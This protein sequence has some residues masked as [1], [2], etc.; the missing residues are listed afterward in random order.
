MVTYGVHSVHMLLQYRIPPNY[1]TQ[2]TV[3]MYNCTEEYLLSTSLW[4]HGI[5]P[6]GNSH[7]LLSRYSLCANTVLLYCIKW[8]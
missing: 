3:Y 2:N 8:T 5:N 1:Y 4:N 6:A 7:M